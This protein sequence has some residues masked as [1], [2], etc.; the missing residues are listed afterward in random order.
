MIV[1]KIRYTTEDGVKITGV[2]ST[3][4]KEYEIKGGI[5]LCHGITVDKDEN[6]K[7]VDLTKKLCDVGFKVLRF[8]FRGHGE[9]NIS[10]EEMTITG[11]ILD[12]E[13]SVQHMLDDFSRIGLL[14]CSFGAEPAIYYTKKHPNIVK[15]LVLWNPVLDY[16]ATFLR[17]E[18]PWGKSIFNEENLKMLEKKGFIQIPGK[19]F[20]IGRKLVKEFSKYKPYLE[21]QK[22]SCPVL[23]IHGTKDTKVP[24]WISQKYGVP[25]NQSDFISVESNHGFGEYK[26]FV[27]DRTIEWFRKH[28]MEE[29]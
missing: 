15:T 11:E 24:Y 7:F 10:S 6:G 27:Y 18:L 22:I 29:I 14:G 28:M 23:T 8:D 2:I 5:V 19:D 3:P 20:K 16:E 1:K 17:P 21:L 13:V 26:E 25:N 9:S 12:L 4:E